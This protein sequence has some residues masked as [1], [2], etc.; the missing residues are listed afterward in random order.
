MKKETGVPAMPDVT[1]PVFDFTFKHESVENP[2]VYHPSLVSRFS[3]ASLRSAFH[4]P[5]HHPTPRCRKNLL[6][7]LRT[8]A[9]CERCSI[10][11]MTFFL[12]L[13]Y[14]QHLRPSELTVLVEV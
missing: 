12:A 13:R 8:A 2:A 10:A 5:L 11:S 7:F 1:D 9:A 14:Q 4:L 6:S 3:L